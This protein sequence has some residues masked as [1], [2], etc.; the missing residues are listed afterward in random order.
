[1]AGATVVGRRRERSRAAAAAQGRWLSGHQRSHTLCVRHASPTNPN[2]P[3]CC[4][5]FCLAG[6]VMQCPE[7]TKCEA[8]N[9]GSPCVEARPAPSCAPLGLKDYDCMD[10]T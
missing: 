10:R 1:M 9:G 7:G 4:S 5:A 3:R 8:G 2:R 6:T